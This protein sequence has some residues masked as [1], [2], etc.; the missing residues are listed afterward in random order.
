MFN[1]EFTSINILG[2]I[3]SF[4]IQNLEDTLVVLQTQHLQITDKLLPEIESCFISLNRNRDANCWQE[5]KDVYQD[6][7]EINELIRDH[8]TFEEHFVFPE[9]QQPKRKNVLTQNFIDAH[10]DFE[11]MIQG[12]I[13]KLQTRLN[14]FESYMAFNIL[15]VKLERLNFV[16]SQHQALEN[17]IF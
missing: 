9:L 4:Q 7:S 10:D 16:L 15:M 11:F 13:A 12:L 8:I 1:L 3:E 2:E 14:K 17:V 5:L 6:F